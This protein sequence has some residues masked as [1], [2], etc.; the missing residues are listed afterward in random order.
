MHADFHFGHAVII[1]ATLASVAAAAEER[2]PVTFKRIV[3]DPVFRSEG[4]AVAD[5]NKDGKLDIL[6]G[7]FWYEGPAWKPHEIREPADYKD[8]AGGYSRCFLCWPDDIDG[9]SWVDLVVIGFPGQ[10]AHWYSNPQGGTGR[11][12]EHLVAPVAG[13]ETPQY[14]DLLGTGRRGIVMGNAKSQV[15]FATPGKDPTQPWETVVIGPEKGPGGSGHGLGV[16]DVNGDG[17]LDVLA[18]GGWYGREASAD[19]TAAWRLHVASGLSG[20]ADIIPYDVDGDGVMDT[21]G[22]SGHGYGIWACLQR[23]KEGADPDFIRQ[24]LFPK[25]FSQSHALCCIDVDGDGMKDL[26]TG[27]RRWAH[28]PKGDAD[29]MDPPV[30]YWFQATTK[31]SG[32]VEFLP[33]KIDNASGIGTQFWV[34]DINADGRTDILVSNKMG[35]HLFEQ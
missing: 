12:K 34:G 14:V 10:K 22:S 20:E 8:G 30:L 32:G 26:V 33:H 15:V 25:L 5:V 13:N 4:V 23:P 28:G 21:I 1:I 17:R 2:P 7:D 6:V 31:P 24:N 35:I 19:G 9:D 29:P 3:V 16:G 11:W 27:K 18:P